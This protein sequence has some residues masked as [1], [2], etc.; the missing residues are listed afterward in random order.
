MLNYGKLSI[1][2]IFLTSSESSSAKPGAVH[3]HFSTKLRSTN[4]YTVYLYQEL[5]PE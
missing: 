3:I 1:L 4:N 2:L 5:V